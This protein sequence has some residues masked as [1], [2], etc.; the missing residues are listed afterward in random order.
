MPK[1]IRMAC[2]T[3]SLTTHSLLDRVPPSA[4]SDAIGLWP[5]ASAVAQGE[6]TR[7]LPLSVSSMT[8]LTASEYFFSF[9]SSLLFHAASICSFNSI[10]ASIF[11]CD[12]EAN[13]GHK[14]L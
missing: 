3:H 11:F 9:N 6:A 4:L 12:R 14:M 5:T 13:L 1:Y 8:F 7:N 2:F 10:I